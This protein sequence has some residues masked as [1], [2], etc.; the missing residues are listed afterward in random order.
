MKTDLRPQS[1]ALTALACGLAATL[2][3]WYLTGSQVEREAQAYGLAGGSPTAWRL[4][5][6]AS[7][8]MV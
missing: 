6:G 1:V 2:L 5:T 7:F 4:V 3:A 8:I